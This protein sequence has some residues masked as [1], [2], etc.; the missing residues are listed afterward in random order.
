MTGRKSSG[1]GGAQA[2]QLAALQEQN[3]QAQADIDALR[4]AT[5]VASPATEAAKAE[6]ETAQKTLERNRGG[7]GRTLLTGGQ[8][9][10]NDNTGAAPALKQLLG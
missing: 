8:G 1:D 10:A 9:L 5:P 7:R 6:A 4:N 3:R 2:A